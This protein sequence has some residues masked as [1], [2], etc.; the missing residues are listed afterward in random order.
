MNFE[1]TII[2]VW[3]QVLVDEAKFVTLDGRR[4]PVRETSRSKLREVDFQFGKETLRGL[5]QNPNTTSR[6]AQLARQEK[7]VMQ[8]LSDG[9][10]IANVIDGKAKIYDRERRT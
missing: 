8:F 3:R 4:S 2:S 5:E 6:W 10:Y 1:E 9:K 7:K